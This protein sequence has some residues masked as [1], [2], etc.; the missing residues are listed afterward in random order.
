MVLLNSKKED[1]TK[2]S[3]PLSSSKFRLIV[4]LFH[5]K[6]FENLK[7]VYIFTV[8]SFLLLTIKFK[9]NGNCKKSLQKKDPKNLAKKFS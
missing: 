4:L 3:F 6:K 8:D 1:K 2:H 9:Q 5:G 7:I